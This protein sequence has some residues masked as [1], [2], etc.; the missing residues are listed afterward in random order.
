M[1][2]IA[3]R[4]INKLV[5]I[6]GAALERARRRGLI[7]DNPARHLDKLKERAYDDLDFYEPAEVW[8][9]V[10]AT[11]DQ[12]AAIF[13]LLAFSG[14]RRGEALALTWRD[15]DFDREVIRVRANWSHGQLVATKGDRVRSVLLVPQL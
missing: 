6:V 5:M 1:G 14:L 2:Q 11:S 12:D 8:Q 3:H 7:T 15:I 9:L 13:V 4:T 10:Y